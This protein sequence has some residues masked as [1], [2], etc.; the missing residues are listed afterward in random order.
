MGAREHFNALK[1]QLHLNRTPIPVLPATTAPRQEVAPPPGV[2]VAEVVPVAEAAAALVAKST[3]AVEAS[4][5]AKRSPCESLEGYE[6]GEAAVCAAEASLR[7][8]R[9]T[10]L[11]A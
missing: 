3:A 6:R 8:L 2:A 11:L 10:G 7:G 5:R 4:L 9:K 1:T